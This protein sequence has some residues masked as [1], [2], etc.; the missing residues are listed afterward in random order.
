MADELAGLIQ[1]V[2]D[3]LAEGILGFLHIGWAMERIRKTQEYMKS[4]TM[5]DFIEDQL[6]ISRR[7]AYN[8]LHCWTTALVLLPA[9]SSSDWESKKI[10]VAQ[11]I[12]ILTSERA[13]LALPF[14]E[15]YGAKT[16]KAT[17]SRARELAKDDEPITA[18]HV[19]RARKEIC[20][21]PPQPKPEAVED[22]PES[23]EELCGRAIGHLTAKVRE[24]CER[25]GMP[26]DIATPIIE[27]AAIRQ[28]AAEVDLAKQHL[29]AI[30]D[31]EPCA[32]LEVDRIVALLSEARRKLM[33]GKPYAPCPYCWGKGRKRGDC[34]ACRPAVDAQPLGWVNRNK[35]G[36]APKELR[37]GAG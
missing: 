16:T 5:D 31:Q 1:H 13:L 28:I 12:P 6:P 18:R 2:R 36:S 35:W 37:E 4:G 9:T 29:R 24:I 32:Q 19:N 8:A 10:S 25:R 22:G 34:D 3:G 20:P 15:T 26:P 11:I 14:P 30:V 17:W 21:E 23:G 7:H 27:G 33:F